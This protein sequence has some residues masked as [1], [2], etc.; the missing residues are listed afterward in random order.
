MS[1][2]TWPTIERS[3]QLWGQYNF[4]LSYLP[5]FSRVIG[6]DSY[7]S[8]LTKYDELIDPRTMTAVVTFIK[9]IEPESHVVMSW[10]STLYVPLLSILFLLILR[11]SVMCN[12]WSLTSPLISKSFFGDRKSK[13]PN[14]YTEP[15][16]KYT[17]W[18][19]SPMK[20]AKKKTRKRELITVKTIYEVPR[21][22][23]VCVAVASASALFWLWHR[24]GR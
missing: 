5:Y 9:S 6:L 10:E 20:Q 4:A 1:M 17:L 21:N 23:K 16:L 15:K 8:G 11:A 12:P 24:F 2:L 7:P 19:S 13:M 3:F 22:P 18:I 14:I